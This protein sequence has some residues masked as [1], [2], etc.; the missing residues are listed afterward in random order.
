MHHLTRGISSLLHSINLI[1]SLSSWFTS[2]CMHHLI[3]VT[4][5]TLTIYLFGLLLQNASVSQIL[6]SVVFLV[7][8]GLPSRI[9]DLDRGR[10]LAFVLVSFLFVFVFGYVCYRLS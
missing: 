1:C 3:T 9:L 2:S 7:P 5:F 4:T 8:F 6:S 10:T